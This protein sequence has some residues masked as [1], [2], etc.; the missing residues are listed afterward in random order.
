VEE[1]AEEAHPAHEEVCV[2]AAGASYAEQRALYIRVPSSTLNN[3]TGCLCNS[4]CL[5]RTTLAAGQSHL[6]KRCT[7]TAKSVHCRTVC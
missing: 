6:G 2:R 3:D 7:C 5:N 1:P 4:I